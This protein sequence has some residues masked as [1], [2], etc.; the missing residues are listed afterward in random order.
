VSQVLLELFEIVL[1]EKVK[2]SFLEEEGWWQSRGSE[3][4]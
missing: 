2:I 4:A 3:A 1:V